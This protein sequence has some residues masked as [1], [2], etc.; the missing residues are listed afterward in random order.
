MASFLNIVVPRFIACICVQCGRGLSQR[1]NN[2]C[3][4]WGPR[5]LVLVGHYDVAGCRQIVG[6]AD[7]GAMATTDDNLWAYLYYRAEGTGL[8]DSLLSGSVMFMCCVTCHR[9]VA[10]ELTSTSCCMMCVIDIQA[11]VAGLAQETICSMKFCMTLLDSPHAD[12]MS[13]M[14]GGIHLVLESRR[15]LGLSTRRK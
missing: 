13:N 4:V 5:V 7:N 11:R 3:R 15:T 10:G 2:D 1:I 12:L 6:V 8:A 9:R 14:G